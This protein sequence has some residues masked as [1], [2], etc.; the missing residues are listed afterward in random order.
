[1]PYPWLSFALAYP[2]KHQRLCYSANQKNSRGLAEGLHNNRSGSLFSETAQSYSLQ[3]L[4][5][6]H[7]RTRFGTE[8]L[9]LETS[10][11]KKLKVMR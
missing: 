8:P 6:R 3:L 2:K 11:Q 9:S 1:M 4:L 7:G 5:S 10:E